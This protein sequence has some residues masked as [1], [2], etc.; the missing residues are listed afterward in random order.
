MEVKVLHG[1][2]A[3]SCTDIRNGALEHGG[4]GVPTVTAEAHLRLRLLIFTGIVQTTQ[5][6]S[7][8]MRERP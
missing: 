5:T 4:V 1:L 7:H 3:E 6:H 8:V 2:K